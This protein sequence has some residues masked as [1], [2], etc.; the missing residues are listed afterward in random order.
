MSA[1]DLRSETLEPGPPPL[2]ETRPRAG[3][4]DDGSAVECGPRMLVGR[5]AHRCHAFGP[6][7]GVG[8]RPHCERRLRGALSD[9]SYEVKDAFGFGDR[10]EVEPLTERAH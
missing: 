6:Q 4:R 5:H 2:L 10:V 8:C 3:G 9:L 7:R 1:S